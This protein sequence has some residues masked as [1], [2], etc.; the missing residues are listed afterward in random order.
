MRNHPGITR[1]FSYRCEGKGVKAREAGNFLGLI[2]V[3]EGEPRSVHLYAETQ[4][5]LMLV[6]VVE[7]DVLSI[8]KI[9]VRAVSR[10]V[11]WYI[12]QCRVP[13]CREVKP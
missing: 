12:A 11:D 9:R 3:W 13:P 6:R 4:A 5:V 2:F 1:S 10:R 7:V 8:L